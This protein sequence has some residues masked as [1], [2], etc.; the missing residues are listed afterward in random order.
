[1][2][3]KLVTKPNLDSKLEVAPEVCE[4]DG[5]D[6]AEVEDEEGADVDV[7]IDVEEDGGL[8]MMS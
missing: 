7:D 8:T 4:G 3:T 6:V 2:T 1:M 5:D